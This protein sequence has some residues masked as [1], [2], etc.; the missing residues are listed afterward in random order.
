MSSLSRVLRVKQ[1]ESM[2]NERAKAARLKIKVLSEEHRE[3][4]RVILRWIKAGKKPVTYLQILDAVKNGAQLYQDLKLL[5]K[6][7]HLTPCYPRRDG[8]AEIH[9]VRSTK[10]AINS[11]LC[12]QR[13]G[14]Y[15]KRVN[16]EL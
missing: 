14:I 3:D 16:D 7:R 9:Y 6:A 12:N 15:I 10:H 11:R 5:V 1:T 4:L 13:R 2:R 8:A